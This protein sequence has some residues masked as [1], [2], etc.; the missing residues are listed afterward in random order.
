M[1]ARGQRS[2]Q[3]ERQVDAEECEHAGVAESR[4]D[5]EQAECCD[6]G[7]EFEV[8]KRYEPVNQ[9]AGGDGS[10]GTQERVLHLLTGL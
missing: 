9:D 8:G 5:R 3:E 2:G 6:G 4:E 1:Q 10:R 7:E